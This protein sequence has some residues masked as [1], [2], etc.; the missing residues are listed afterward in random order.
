[1]AGI[2]TSTSLLAAAPSICSASGLPLTSTTTCSLVMMAAAASSSPTTLNGHRPLIAHLSAFPSARVPA[3]VRV[4][5]ERPLPA[6]K[7]RQVA[8][9]VYRGDCLADARGGGVGDEDSECGSFE[10]ASLEVGK[11]EGEAF[12]AAEGGEVVDEKNG[13]VPLICCS[14]SIGRDAG[15]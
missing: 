11:P 10:L 14:R 1:M 8:R 6:R 12:A 7:P 4:D 5:E 13:G 15:P 3:R 9:Q 2:I